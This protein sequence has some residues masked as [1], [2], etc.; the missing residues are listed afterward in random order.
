[1]ADMMLDFI[2]VILKITPDVETPGGKDW[3]TKKVNLL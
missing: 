2:V 1:M 3:L